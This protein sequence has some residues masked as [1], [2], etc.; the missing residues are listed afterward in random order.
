MIHKEDI[1]NILKTF[2]DP[3][4]DQD[5]VSA[6]R[7]SGIVIR[8]QKIVITLEIAPEELSAFSGKLKAW[9]QQ[10]ESYVKERQVTFILTSANQPAMEA[11]PAA[12][13][14]SK[15][16]A[17][18]TKT[19]VGKI[20]QMIVV[21]SGKGGV[22]KSTI[23]VGLARE[24]AAQ[25]ERVGL[26]DIDI[27]GPSV[28]ILMGTEQQKLAV[29]E[30]QLAPL[31]VDQVKVISF[32]NIV[33]PGVAAIWRGPM[34]TKALHQMMMT[35]NWGEVTTLVIDTPPGTGDILV[36]LAENYPLSG[37][38][39]VSTAHALSVS[40]VE[41]SL[42]LFKKMHIPI[43]GVIENMSY[44]EDENNATQIPLINNEFFLKFL[45]KESL[46]LLGKLA[47]IP[48]ISQQKKAV[49]WQKSKEFQSIVS[50]IKKT[51][52]KVKI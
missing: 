39:L 26:L 47:F 52:E 13:A 28:P 6:E 50:N 45:E 22:G 10:L 3:C 1:L 19:W 32:G 23:A 35:T 44:L 25:G 48:E 43:L 27:Y 5:L 49:K 42:S 31:E 38:V 24:L 14:S 36:S 29:I 12:T 18:K 4:L 15:S 20:K 17:Q 21:A 41:R 9:E 11:K 2:P 40:D 33:E 30:N 37:V 51:L 34:V 46:P 8:E 7:I 16:A